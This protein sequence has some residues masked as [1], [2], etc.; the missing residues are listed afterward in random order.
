RRELALRRP[1]ERVDAQMRV[2]MREHAI[3]KAWPAG[4]RLL[5]CLGPSPAS[6]RL[7]RAAKRMADRLGSPWIAAYVETPQQ[8]RLPQ[9]ARDGVIQMMRLA[10]PR[11]GGSRHPRGPR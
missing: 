4:E 9:T 1:A 8:T 2:Y 7:V 6:A 10:G 5:V 3:E 11:G